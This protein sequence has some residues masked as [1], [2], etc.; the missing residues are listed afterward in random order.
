ML[1]VGAAQRTPHPAALRQT[2]VVALC[3]R[4]GSAEDVAQDIGVCRE[5]LFHWKNQLPGREAPAKPRVGA[6]V[7]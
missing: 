5:T 7:P 1:V 2:A 3:M 4:P 6:G